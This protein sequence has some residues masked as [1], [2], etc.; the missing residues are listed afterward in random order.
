[1]QMNFILF[2]FTVL[3]TRIVLSDAL[4]GSQARMA[5]SHAQPGPNPLTERCFGHGPNCDVYE[6]TRT[7]F[8]KII[9]I[10][11]LLRLR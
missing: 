7:Q 10:G 1:M 9:K 6:G 3:S 2:Q 5:V 8:P 4:D 11:S